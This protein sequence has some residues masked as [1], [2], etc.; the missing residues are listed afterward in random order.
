MAKKSDNREV[1]LEQL[2]EWVER[3]AAYL[4]QDGMPP[5]AGRIL[6]WLM[7]CEPYEQSASEISEAIGASRASITT[8]MQVLGALGFI[9]RRTRPGS[10]TEYFR[11]ESGAWE[12]VVRRQ[13][14]G[15]VAFGRIAREGLSLL[16]RG[17]R[18]ARLLEA[19]EIFDWLQGVFDEADPPPSGHPIIADRDD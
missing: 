12:A 4:A 11:L 10:R 13:V 6:G 17:P 9:A 19:Q 16:G 1:S 15:L 7:V 18:G 2:L 14:A 3:V 8:N 5:I